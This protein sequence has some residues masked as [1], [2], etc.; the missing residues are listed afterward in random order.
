MGVPA[1]LK[2]IMRKKPE[3]KTKIFHAGFE[4]LMYQL[5]NHEKKSKKTKIILC[6]VRTVSLCF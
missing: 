2:A 6:C 5:D 4:L 1:T 3:K